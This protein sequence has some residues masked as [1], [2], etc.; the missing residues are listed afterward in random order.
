MLLDIGST[1]VH[2]I[3][4]HTHLSSYQG[5]SILS[6]KEWSALGGL[7]TANM[8][9]TLMQLLRTLSY[10][11]ASKFPNSR[12]SLGRFHSCFLPVKWH[13]AHS[14]LKSNFYHFINLAYSACL[15]DCL[16]WS[17]QAHSY[18][19]PSIYFFP[20]IDHCFSPYDT[21]FK[22]LLHGYCWESWEP[23]HR[24]TSWEYT[25]IFPELCFRGSWGP[26]HHNLCAIVEC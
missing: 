7:S 26:E 13:R 24:E 12:L 18:S 8:H 21:Q 11:P 23:R 4:K 14:E 25:V 2:R 19:H 1:H 10:P 22:C 5:K 17:C 3:W 20:N 15:S 9:A 6:K 16:S